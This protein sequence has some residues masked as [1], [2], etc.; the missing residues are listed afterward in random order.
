MGDIVRIVKDE[1]FFVDLVFLF[2]DRFDGLCYVIIVS[3]D[4]EINLKVCLCICF[5]IVLGEYNVLCFCFF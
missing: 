2:L 4:G 3:L 1:I 5:S